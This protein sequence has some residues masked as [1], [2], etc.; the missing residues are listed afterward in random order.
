MSLTELTSSA[1]LEVAL[2]EARAGLGEGGIP[3]ALHCCISD[4]LTG[5]GPAG[6]VQAGVAA[7]TSLRCRVSCFRHGEDVRC[8]NASVPSACCSPFP[9]R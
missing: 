3:M 8:L 4:R 5:A 1:L 7:R 2:A 6:G 9:S